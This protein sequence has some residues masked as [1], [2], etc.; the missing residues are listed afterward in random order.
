[1]TDIDTADQDLGEEV[2]QEVIEHDQELQ[3]DV[4][5]AKRS[6]S[7]AKRRSSEAI[8]ELNQWRWEMT[9]CPLG[10]RYSAL[11]YS[12]AVGQSHTTITRGAA[13]WEAA[14]DSVHDAQ[15]CSL[16]NEPHDARQI[17]PPL[18]D[19]QIDEHDKARRRVDNKEVKA[20]MIERL[21]A[22]FG[23]VP[24]TVEVNHRE[25]VN[26]A[27]VRLRSEIDLSETT[28]E[29]V[30]AAADKIAGQIRYEVQLR[31]S[32][33]REV[34]RWMATN[35]AVS[36]ND[37]KMSDVRK[38]VDRI[39][40]TMERK[41]LSWSEAETEVR[42]WDFKAREADRIENEMLKRARHAVLQLQKASVDMRLAAIALG[43]ALQSIETDEIAIGDDEMGLIKLNIEDS[44]AI[45]RQAKAAVTGSSNVD[46]DSALRKLNKEEG[47]A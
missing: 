29:E 12:K 45:V 16:G 17:P 40:R 33:E 23:T 3:G 24:T 34:K 31:E 9:V 46:W 6:L 20:I 22:H 38:M 8:A 42:E 25:R 14:S 47:A 19:D 13:A 28:I 27:L 35:R 26:D 32:H 5:D 4:S 30:T 36:S 43:K 18:T 15:K 39:E 11:A 41:E 2:H 10:P 37:V 21:A 44:W 7:G 1:M